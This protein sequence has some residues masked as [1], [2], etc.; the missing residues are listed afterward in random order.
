MKPKVIL[1]GLGI[2]AETAFDS[3]RAHCQMAAVVRP[4]SA[5]PDPV[6]DQAR[7]AGVPVFDGVTPAEIAELV[8]RLRPDAVVVSSYD[9]I[10]KG[11]LLEKSLFINVH[12]SPLPQYRGRANV[13]WALI[14]QEPCAAL[15]IHR[16]EP[17][18]DAGNILFQQLI[19]VGRQDTVTSLYERLNEI[20]RIH[21]GPTA[22]RAVEG[23]AGEVQDEEAATYGCTRTP[24]DGEIDWSQSTS[25]IDGLIRALTPPF[26]GAFTYLAGRKLVIWRA[27]IVEAPPRFTG[28]VPGRVVARNGQNGSVEVLTGDGVIRIHEVQRPGDGEPVAATEV[29]RSVKQT[30]GLR[31]SDLAERIEALETAVRALA[32]TGSRTS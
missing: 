9:R 30:L 14:N 26:P 8:E 7:D 1:I 15:S 31:M 16:L 2:T 13:N 20:Q 12:Y 18:L 28:R 5:S 29:I 17:G 19:P 10:L 22:V 6:R 4:P 11:D 23:W 27:S 24:A 3:L 21:L 25:S 32:Q